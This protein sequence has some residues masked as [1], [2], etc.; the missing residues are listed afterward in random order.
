MA[1]IG[2]YLNYVCVELYDRHFFPGEKTEMAHGV[3]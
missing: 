3:H 1:Q 2:I